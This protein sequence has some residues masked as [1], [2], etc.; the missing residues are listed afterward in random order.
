VARL[1]G[2]LK[3]RGFRGKHL[4]RQ[5]VRDLLPAPVLARRKQGFGLPLARWMRGELAGL[6]RGLLTD[7]TARSRG[8]FEPAKVL[9]LLDQHQAGVDHG[10][11]L[12]NLMVL[13]LWFREF[14]DRPKAS[15]AV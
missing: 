11:R 6:A 7:Q 13:E 8:M 14:V 5:A 10:E 15:P 4:L 2:A 12:W 9:Q 3:L 1:S